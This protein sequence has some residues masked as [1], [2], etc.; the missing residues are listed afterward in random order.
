MTA[1]NHG[2]L[3]RPDPRY[4][5]I[6]D[7]A[8]AYL[9][10]TSHNYDIISSDCTDLRYKSSGSLYD[11]EYF[12]RCRD[13]L[14]S[15][16]IVVV[17]MP[18]G[19]LSDAMFRVVLRTF[20]RVFPEMAV[21][22]PHN[23]W[24]HFVLLVGWRDQMTI[25]FDRIAQR[26]TEPDVRADMA[27]IGLNNPYQLLASFVAAGRDLDNYLAGDTLNTRNHP[28]IE[29]EAPK[30][31]Y[32]RQITLQ[33]LITLM[34]HRASV[35]PWVVG[36]QIDWDRYS[37]YERAVPHILEGQFHERTMDFEAATLAYLRAKRLTPDDEQ[38]EKSLK[39]PWL[40]QLA[41][42]GNPSAWLLLGRSQQLQGNHTLALQMFNVYGQRLAELE[43]GRRTA[44]P[45]ILHQARAWSQTA[46]TWRDDCLRVLAQR[47]QQ[48][49]PPEDR[50]ARP[51]DD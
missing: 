37:N 28:I 51:S 30:Q 16:G 47:K 10:Y 33:N 14:R 9:R 36:Q 25:D 26:L 6:F 8:A 4:R 2:F 49:A 5:L 21:F 35:R 27:E 44:P 38:V 34:R 39:L 32:V 22:Y 31:G 15:G 43:S 11:L 17:W 3:D 29:F 18:L 40:T 41:E 24:T 23:Q 20:Y 48:E 19:G 45:E 46:K 12:Q 42:Q 50:E 13:K 1:A 7:D